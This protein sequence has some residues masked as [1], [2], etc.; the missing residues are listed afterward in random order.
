MDNF[1]YP[2]CMGWYYLQATMNK[3]EHRVGGA[4]RTKPQTETTF[5]LDSVRIIGAESNTI[6][7]SSKISTFNV[8]NKNNKIHRAEI[9]DPC[10]AVNNLIV[11]SENIKLDGFDYKYD[12]DC[13]IFILRDGY[14][15]N[16]IKYNK[17]K[18]KIIFTNYI[19]SISFCMSINKF[20]QTDNAKLSK[21]FSKITKIIYALMNTNIVNIYR[22]PIA[23]YK[24]QQIKDIIKGELTI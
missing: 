20:L 21:D 17:K 24:L 22:S 1:T 14:M 13:L 8:I 12:S 19:D 23:L 3:N 15:N 11:L 18:Q 4:Y 6:L 5:S 7:N 16:Y 2:N 9:I 10:N